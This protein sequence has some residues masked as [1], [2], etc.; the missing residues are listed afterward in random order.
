VNAEWTSVRVQT[1]GNRSAVIAALF[2]AGAESV[3]ELDD[4]V[5]THLR[6]IDRA[7]VADAVHRADAAA[8]VEFSPT[9]PIDWSERW[10]ER[11]GA[12]RLGDLVVTPPWLADGYSAD[13]RIIIDPGM[14]FGTGEHETTRGVIRL[15]QREVRGGDVVADLGAGSAVLSIAAAKLGAARVVAIENDPDAIGNAEENVARNGVEDRVAVIEGDA[16]IFLPL[17]APVRIVLA[18]IVSSVIR[19]LL[20]TVNASLSSSGRAIVSGMLLEE[21]G[22]ME[23]VF[24]AGGWIVADSDHEG[25]WWSATIARR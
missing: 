17:V 4:G 19:E 3:Q 15:M 14:A 21:R 16:R 5:V 10:R 23:V 2:Q 7:R 18:N 13:E 25:Q 6:N 20:P 22:G 1:S 24:D 9:P 11:I 8:G 12:H